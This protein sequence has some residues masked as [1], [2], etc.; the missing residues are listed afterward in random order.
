[1]LFKS[2]QFAS[3][4]ATMP[5]RRYMSFTLISIQ[6]N[7][8]RIAIIAFVAYMSPM[9]NMDIIIKATI[10]LRVTVNEKILHLEIFSQ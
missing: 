6:N 2:F 10:V 8:A 5:T 3:K 4:C 1:M 7:L 9:L